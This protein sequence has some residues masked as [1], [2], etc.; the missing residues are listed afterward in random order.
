MLRE[1]LRHSLPVVFLVVL[2]VPVTG[3]TPDIQFQGHDGGG[4]P[5][6]RSLLRKLAVPINFNGFRDPKTGR[7]DPRITLEEALDRLA[8]RRDLTFDVNEEAFKAEGV[9]DVLGVRVATKP[10]PRM[11][12]APIAA[13]L[14]KILFAA[15]VPADTTWIV[16]PDGAI[17]ITTTRFVRAELPDFWARAREAT[18]YASLTS[19]PLED[20]RDLLAEAV[21]I[22][23]ALTQRPL[24]APTEQD[25]APHGKRRHFLPRP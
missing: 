24:V 16:R 9:K 1:T 19:L 22:H 14:R 17:E 3:Q 20:W 21:E 12:R 11:R 13:V 25:S 4:H 6:P 5:P 15:C 10:L 18:A 7:P 8:D 2:A 23:A